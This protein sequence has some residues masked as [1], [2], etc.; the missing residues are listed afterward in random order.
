MI[1]YVLPALVMFLTFV[2][3]L[4]SNQ[5]RVTQVNDPSALS[6]I[7]SNRQSEAIEHYHADITVNADGTVDVTETIRVRVLGNQIRRGIFRDIPTVYPGD[8]LPY[9]S[10]LRISAVER[11][12]KPESYLR[13]RQMG[14]Q[15]LY[16]GHEDVLLERGVHEY[17]ISYSMD[18]MIRFFDEYDELYWNVTGNYWG[19]TIEQASAIVRFPEGSS[20][21]QYNAYTGSIG[22]TDQDFEA[23]MLDESTIRFTGTTPL[24]AS[25]GITVAAA[26]PTGVIQAPDH[27]QLFRWRWYRDFRPVTTAILVFIFLL[28]YYYYAWRRYGID[29]K[30]GAV[31]P[32]FEPPNGMG[33]VEAAT[34]YRNNFQPGMSSAALMELA[35]KGYISIEVTDKV[36][37]RRPRTFKITAL[38]REYGNDLH[39]DSKLLFESLFG[40]S[41]SRRSSVT[42]GGSYS[43]TVQ[44]AVN[45]VRTHVNRLI[46]KKFEFETPFVVMGVFTGI[47]VTA[48]LI[49]NSIALTEHTDFMILWW[50]LGGGYVVVVYLILP[51][52]MKSIVMTYRARVTLIH[53]ILIISLLILSI[54]AVVNASWWYAAWPG[55]IMMWF[56][57]AGGIFCNLLWRPTEEGRK[58]LDKIMGFRM[59]L[60]TS[61]VER[62]RHMGGPELTPE[63]YED[64]V[65]YAMALGVEKQWTRLFSKVL[66]REQWEQVERRTSRYYMPGVHHSSSSLSS[67]LGAMSSGLSSATSTSATPPSSSGSGGGGSSG[68]GGG[69]GGGGGW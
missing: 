35:M 28:A 15:R 17:T 46:N 18:R 64:Y 59:F 12:G 6:T 10:L 34:I 54:H 44:T 9:R 47:V 3:N 65:P 56:G 32:L 36:K 14:Y 67:S 37:L 62:I 4:Q 11:N 16:I 31:I 5:T 51:L 66:S 23:V 43:K 2:L 40:W 69:G 30:G 48:V 53:W 25:E 61:E 20:V 41:S 38:K 45:R 26:I 24:A 27:A 50:F 63:L 21:L 68:G 22:S 58:K 52:I 33:P 57:L 7:L 55:I 49:S 60:Q 29:P 39:E 42:L 8:V 19:F 1:R 13:E